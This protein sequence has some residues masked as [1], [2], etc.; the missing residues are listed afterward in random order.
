MNSTRFNYGELANKKSKVIV[1][2]LFIT[3][4]FRLNTFLISSSVCVTQGS[5]AWR[6]N[7]VCL[8][9]VAVDFIVNA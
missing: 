8:F 7:E 6:R 2:S 5:F 1:I 9:A 4:I 3:N